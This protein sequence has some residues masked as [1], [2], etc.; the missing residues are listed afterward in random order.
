MD[1][2]CPYARLARPCTRNLPLSNLRY[3][4][5][6]SKTFESFIHYAINRVRYGTKI[7]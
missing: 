3:L 1:A 7:R 4:A 2:S 6:Y 5:E